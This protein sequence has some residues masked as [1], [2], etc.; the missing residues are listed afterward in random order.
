MEEGKVPQETNN[1]MRG[2]FTSDANLKLVQRDLTRVSSDVE[3]TTSNY[4]SNQKPNGDTDLIVLDN[5]LEGGIYITKTIFHPVTI[6]NNYPH[7][8]ISFVS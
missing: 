5:L 7:K 1:N 6:S 8:S 2:I 4:L 3:N